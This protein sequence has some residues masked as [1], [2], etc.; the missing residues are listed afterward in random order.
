MHVCVCVNAGQIPFIFRK[1]HD[2]T[3]IRDEFMPGL[4][5]YVPLTHWGRGKMADI[6]Q[7]TLSNAFSG[8]KL[9]EFRLKFHWSL[10]NQ[11]YSS[12]GSDNGLAPIRRKP[13]SEA[14]LVILLTHKCVNRPQWVNE[15][16]AMLS[17]PCILK[18]HEMRFLGQFTIE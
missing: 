4:F 16:A 2:D 11:Q 6:S 9:L 8:M 7:T 5:I 13:L 12:I 14:M 1:I 18:W 10:S 15:R 3:A 17:K